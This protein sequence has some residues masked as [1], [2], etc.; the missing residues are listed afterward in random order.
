MFQERLSSLLSDD[1]TS[2]PGMTRS[3]LL[4]SMIGQIGGHR[5]ESKGTGK[6]YPS[7]HSVGILGSFFRSGALREYMGCTLSAVACSMKLTVGDPC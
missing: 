5:G 2:L 3:S 7:R 1:V 6:K 4:S